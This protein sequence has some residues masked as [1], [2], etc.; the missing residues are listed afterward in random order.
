MALK[1]ILIPTQEFVVRGETIKVRGLSFADIAY[2]IGEHKDDLE[3]I[4]RRAREGA[5]SGEDMSGMVAGLIREMPDLAAKIVAC[6]A[7]E[8]EAADVVKRLPFPT[9][10][11]ILMAVG[12][13]TFEETGG[14]KKFAENVIAIMAATSSTL[15]DLTEKA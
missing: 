4:V 8:P 11:E 2:L 1:N 12:R 15:S 9:L 7:D 10:L 6:A 13:L 3:E 14:V 5:S